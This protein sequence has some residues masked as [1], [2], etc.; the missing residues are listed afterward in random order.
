MWADFC[1]EPSYSV[2]EISDRLVSMRLPKAA[3]YT[4]SALNSRMKI[5]H[6]S[7][8][9]TYGR[10]T[11]GLILITLL[12]ARVD[13]QAVIA[14]FTH[15]RMD[16]YLFALTLF[17]LSIVVSAYRWQL[18]LSATGASPT[19]GQLTAINLIGNFFS[20]F[21]PTAVGG[22]VVRIAEL[23]YQGRSDYHHN[24]SSVMLDRLVGLISLAIMAAIALIAGFSTVQNETIRI[25][26][27]AAIV[28]LASGWFLFFNKAL[29]RKFQWLVR[30]PG[31]HRLEPTCIRLYQ[32]LYDLHSRQQLLRSSVAISLGLQIIEVIAVLLM[33]RSLGIQ[34]SALYFFL[35]LPLIWL[36]TMIPLSLN[37]L[38]L[39]EGAFTFFF[40]LVGVA[41]PAA[42]ALSFLVYSAR[43]C[44][45]LVGGLLYARAT[46]GRQA[47]PVQ[48]VA[49]VIPVE[50]VLQ[51]E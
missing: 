4:T 29:I 39:R 15:L 43:L 17:F 11:L 7:K 28:G 12:I 27:L 9:L 18:I 37:G 1:R 32:S 48:Q 49:A 36:I 38:G 42:V 46:V 30:L 19:I 14:T 45:G 6:K 41:A 10:L 31:L 23:T 13:R 34:L 22:D 16:Y 26:V 50:A 21:L 47:Q 40:G 33:A 2:R 3:A 51:V 20:N 24:I 8:L 44:S 35:F 25:I 5:M